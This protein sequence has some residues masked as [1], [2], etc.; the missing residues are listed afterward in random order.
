MIDASASVRSWRESR[1]VTRAAEYTATSDL[2]WGN[3]R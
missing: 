1:Q 3:H 2:L